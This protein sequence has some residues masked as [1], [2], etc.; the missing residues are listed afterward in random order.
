[1][2]ALDS[3][4]MIGSRSISMATRFTYTI[5]AVIGQWSSQAVVAADIAAATELSERSP[6]LAWPD[7]ALSQSR[8]C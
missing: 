1:M 3:L 8:T 7:L 2:G 4:E 5:D 6:H